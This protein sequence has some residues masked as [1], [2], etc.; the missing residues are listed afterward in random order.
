MDYASHLGHYD[1]HPFAPTVG[2]FGGGLGVAVKF[3][4]KRVLCLTYCVEAGHVKCQT[5]SCVTALGELVLAPEITRLIL[6][7][8]QTAIL[9]ELPVVGKASQITPFSKNGQGDD[10]TNTGH[11]LEN[12]I[13][14]VVAKRGFGLLLQLLP[15][16]SEF[17]ASLE[18]ELKGLAGQSILRN[19]Y[20]NCV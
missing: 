12:A 17:L 6:G 14:R 1:S 18:F 2:V 20:A 11:R 16:S 4:T 9:Q 13:V 3:L 8:V 15:L 19:G 10:G 7:Q 5:E